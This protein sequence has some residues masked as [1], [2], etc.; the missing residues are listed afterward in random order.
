MEEHNIS[1]PPLYKQ[2]TIREY[3]RKTDLDVLVE[4]GSCMG[5]TIEACR[6]IGRY[7]K[8]IYS[9]ELGAD[10]HEHCRQRFAAYP[11]IHLFQGDSGEVL[12][13]L[14]PLIDRPAIFWLDAHWSGGG[15][16]RGPFDS[17]ISDELAAILDW[18]QAYPMSVILIDDIREFGIKDDYPP[19]SEI[20]RRIKGRHPTWM[21]EV[22]DDI[23]RAHAPIHERT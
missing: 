21:F 18:T 14:L 20:E 10:L 4:T 19:I 6:S 12:T 23:A 16:A 9:I 22:R 15:T 1:P 7:F 13:R 3:A 11:N 8:D 5:D 17:A 2:W